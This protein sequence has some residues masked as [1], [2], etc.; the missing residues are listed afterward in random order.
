MAYV[1]FALNVAVTVCFAISLNKPKSEWPKN[2]MILMTAVYAFSV[3]GALVSMRL[4]YDMFGTPE[5]DA[6]IFASIM[7]FG[8]VN[9]LCIMASM[10]IAW[11]LFQKKRVKAALITGF[12]TLIGVPTVNG[13]LAMIAAMAVLMNFNG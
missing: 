3:V 10:P 9:A 4:L 5:V 13:I 7:T 11:A 6:I 2:T 1:L 12:V 8:I